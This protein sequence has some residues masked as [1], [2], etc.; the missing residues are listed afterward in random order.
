VIKLAQETIGKG[1]EDEYERVVVSC[2]CLHFVCG[3]SF[4]FPHFNRLTVISNPNFTVN[5]QLNARLDKS[6]LSNDCLHKG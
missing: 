2:V 6:F 3:K 5:K 1:L 4:L